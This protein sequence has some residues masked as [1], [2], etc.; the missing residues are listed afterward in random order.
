M[1]KDGR[2][3]EKGFIPGLGTSHHGFGKMYESKKMSSQGYGIPP[4]GLG[5]KAWGLGHQQFAKERQ[6]QDAGQPQYDISVN[7]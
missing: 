4:K 7:W 6:T 2:I 3:V 1:E 5:L